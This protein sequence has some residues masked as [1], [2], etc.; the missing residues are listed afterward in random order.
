MD[1]LSQIAV[2]VL[3]TIVWGLLTLGISTAWNAAFAD[4]TCTKWV[5]QNALTGVQG[6]SSS[7]CSS[8][9]HKTPSP[10]WGNTSAT[11]VPSSGTPSYPVDATS[12][13]SCDDHLDGFDNQGNSAQSTENGA[14]GLQAV[15][16]TGS[17]TCSNTQQMDL[18]DAISQSSNNSGG[19]MCV[20]G[21]QFYNT[22]STMIV[23]PSGL[24]GVHQV[25][26]AQGTGASCGSPTPGITPSSNQ[27]G[28]NCFSSGG[29]SYCV[30]D[31]DDQVCVA[32]DCWTPKNLPKNSCTGFASGGAACSTNATPPAPSTSTSTTAMATPSATET[33]GSG[34]NNYYYN[35]TVVGA[36]KNPVIFG[37][38]SSGGSSSSSGASSSGGLGGGST[39]DGN[40][41]A[42]TECGNGKESSSGGCVDD[43]FAGGATC[44]SPPVCSGDPIQCAQAQQEYLLRCP[45]DTE[46][47]LASAIGDTGTVASS[48]QDFSSVVSE[49]G[50][51]ATGAGSCPAPFTITV[52]GMSVD[53]DLYS[54][55]CQFAGAISWMVMAIAY[56]VAARAIALGVKG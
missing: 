17:C 48:T 33:D 6:D 22:A 14:V 12:N 16:I 13:G 37:S 34:G 21:C 28:D 26:K 45:A 51:V 31:P 42:G 52:G 18:L 15:Q 39:G 46:S 56:L 24:S 30:N 11:F 10:P 20:N 2:G 32:G 3:R 25:S 23:G 38:S 55:V 35:S 9:N 5:W 7:A 40:G 29:K 43:S 54:K 36:S 8:S 53:V 1:T 49:S 47:D 19:S 4:S 27:G 50:A 41:N 44:Q